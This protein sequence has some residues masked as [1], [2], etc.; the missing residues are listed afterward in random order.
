MWDILIIVAKLILAIILGGIIGIERETLGKPA[1]SR[2][3]AL[4]ALGSTLF[5]ILSIQGFSQ[6]PNAVP[7]AMAAQIVTGIGFLGAGLIIFHKE[8]LEGLTT[9]AALWAVAAV[10]VTIGIGWYLVATITSFLIFLLLF[11]VRKIEFSKNKKNTLWT[12]FDKK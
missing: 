3:Y 1:G 6:L 7:G 2:T 5:T 12:L 8:K 4:I 11:I 10:G 9:A